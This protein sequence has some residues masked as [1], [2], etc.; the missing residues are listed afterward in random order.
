ML[1]TLLLASASVALAGKCNDKSDS[2]AAWARAG[3]C[4]T[5]EGL[6][7]ICPLSCGTCTLDCIEKDESCVAWAQAGECENNP[8]HMLKEC[9]IACGICSATEC[10]DKKFQC[11]SWARANACND[12]P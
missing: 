5:N 9:P 10:T 1:R 12:N 6:A 7:A 3:E 11:D 8:I 2:C 4:A